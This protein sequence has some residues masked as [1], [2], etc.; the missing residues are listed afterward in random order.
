ME[1]KT[2]QKFVKQSRGRKNKKNGRKRKEKGGERG[3]G[4]GVGRER[5]GSPA[6]TSQASIN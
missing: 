1:R 3:K 4:K 5:Q 6:L 2:K